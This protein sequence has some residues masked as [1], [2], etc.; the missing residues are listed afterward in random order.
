MSLEHRLEPESKKALKHPNN[1]Y[2][3]DAG[4]NVLILAIERVPKVGATNK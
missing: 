4:A 3:R 1:G 2:V